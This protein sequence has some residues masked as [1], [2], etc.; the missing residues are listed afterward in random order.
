MKQDSKKEKLSD[1][2]ADT[3]RQYNILK[4]T[5]AIESLKK[6]HKQ[7][8]AH[9]KKVEDM[10]ALLIKEAMKIVEDAGIKQKV[11]VKDIVSGE[12]LH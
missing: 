12:E 2:T 6:I 9:N 11:D 10:L 3:L 5:D 1:L 7:S 8:A 4:L